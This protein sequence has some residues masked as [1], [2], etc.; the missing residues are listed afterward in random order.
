MILGGPLD[1]GEEVLLVVD[2][3]SEDAVRR[4]LDYP[5]RWSVGVIIPS[6]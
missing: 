5:A 4:A 6:V 3:E 2:S 1:S